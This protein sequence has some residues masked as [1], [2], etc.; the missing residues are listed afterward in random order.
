MAHLPHP[1]MIKGVLRVTG[2]RVIRRRAQD[3]RGSDEP[4]LPVLHIPGGTHVAQLFLSSKEARDR[5]VEERRKRIDGEATPVMRV[6][7]RALHRIVK[8]FGLIQ[9]ERCTKV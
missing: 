3:S 1:D 7:T 8:A 4:N 5:Q 6:P 2:E 9:R